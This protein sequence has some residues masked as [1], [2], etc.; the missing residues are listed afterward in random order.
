MNEFCKS[1][2]F[3]NLQS[4]SF[5]RGHVSLFDDSSKKFVDI[6][7]FEL[8]GL[9][10]NSIS[11]VEEV[12]IQPITSTRYNVVIYFHSQSISSKERRM[13]GVRF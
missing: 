11:K 2:S 12:K 5:W 13:F 10:S 3:D 9:E 8:S 1:F 6:P 7:G 4:T